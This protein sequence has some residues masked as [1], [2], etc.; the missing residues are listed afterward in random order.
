MPLAGVTVGVQD[1]VPLAAT[2][3]GDGVQATGLPAGS[4]ITTV[5]PTSP[6]PEIVEPLDGLTTG[7]VGGVMSTRI[8]SRVGLLVLPAGSV[9]VTVKG[10]EP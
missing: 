2:M 1:H 9:A 7:A 4:L 8:G 3:V 5:A 6:V 10:L